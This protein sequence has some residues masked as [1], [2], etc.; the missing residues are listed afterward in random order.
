MDNG[1]LAHNTQ[2]SQKI[3]WYSFFIHILFNFV[4]YNWKLCHSDLK[5]LKKYV[6]KKK[7]LQGGYCSIV[8]ELDSGKETITFLLNLVICRSIHNLI[9]FPSGIRT[10]TIAPS[11]C[12]QCHV[13]P[14][15]KEINQLCVLPSYGGRLPGR[16]EYYSMYLLKMCLLY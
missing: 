10:K 6:R 12:S 11:S 1:K 9:F 8:I 7:E 2:C 5:T 15:L 14:L 16:W 3:R 13:P 4:W